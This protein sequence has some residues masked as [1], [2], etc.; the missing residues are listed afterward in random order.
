MRV[1]AIR[2]RMGSEALPERA[3]ADPL[4]ARATLVETAS[5]I[6]VPE[7]NRA[8]AAKNNPVPRAVAQR[9]IKKVAVYTTKDACGSTTA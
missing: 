1:E 6:G 9:A 8:V 5:R 4:A 2:I 3:D 7:G